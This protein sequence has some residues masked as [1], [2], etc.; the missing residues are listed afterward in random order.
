[1][2]L[3]TNGET[4]LDDTQSQIDALVKGHAVVLFMK[5][6]PQ[7]PRCG[8]SGRAARALQLCGL[9]PKDYLA[10]D[11]LQDEALR[12]GVKVYAQWPTIPQLFIRGELIGGSDI[13]AEMQSSGELQKRL[14]APLT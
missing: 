4:I 11:V 10:V 14:A 3:C 1:M 13:M 7:F 6:T 8:F 5:G 12:E 2:Q 9:T